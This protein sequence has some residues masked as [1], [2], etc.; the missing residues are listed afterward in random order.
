[1]TAQTAIDQEILLRYPHLLSP[2]H[3]CM[4]AM[5]KYVC[6]PHLWAINHQIST[7]AM[8]RRARLAINVPLRHG[9]TWLATIGLASWI[10][11]TDPDTRIAIASYADEYSEK[12]AGEV[13]D[14][15]EK[16]GPE[17]GIRL[18]KDSK[19]KARWN[20]Q[21]RQ[22]AMIG[23]GRH[24][25][26]NGRDADLI[27][28][29]DM[30][31]DHIEAV[32]PKTMESV[33]TWYLTSVYGRLQAQ[34]SIIAVGTRWG[35]NDWYG[36]I[37]EMSKKTGE[38]WQFIVYR[39]LAEADD[40]L[41]RAVGEALC[42]ELV[43]PRELNI[44]KIQT[45]YWFNCIYQQRPTA[46]GGNLFT[47][48]AWPR[49]DDLGNC[50]QVVKGPHNKKF[51]QKQDAI[52]IVAA[53]WAWSEKETGDCT[54]IGAGAL[55]PDGDLLVLDVVNDRF[56]PEGLAPAVDLMCKKW[57]PSIVGI[58]EGHPTLKND[59]V[60]H[61]H[62]PS[63]VIWLKPQASRAS[64][65][66]KMARAVPAMLRGQN[67]TIVLPAAES[68]TERP[69]MEDFTN[70]LMKFGPIDLGPATDDM[71]DMLA[72]MARLA[73]QYAPLA[74]AAAPDYRAWAPLT[75]GRETGWKNHPW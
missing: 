30:I 64:G 29:D 32:Q 38:E 51:V 57:R 39:A 22:G 55:T 35:I 19:A 74:P 42:P 62:V 5:P 15:V 45:P 6:Y 58:E 70:Q 43:D 72:Y 10:L 40:P 47:P 44:Q 7:A 18:R 49:Y 9:K 13:K 61:K 69:W 1:M 34:S 60:R 27:I 17:L 63:T 12:R 4:A 33:W 26:F 16:F 66:G 36:R 2:A 56:P 53:D 25:G 41:G 21:G 3:L 20:I 37:Q 71:V 46:E 11:L 50:W 48:G 52:V 65:A 14:I 24:G 75:P 68:G 54:A 23:V 8:R 67:G 28:M 31:K 59:L 73:E